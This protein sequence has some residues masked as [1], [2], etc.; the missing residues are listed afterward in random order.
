MFWKK[1]N[2]LPF[3]ILFLTALIVRLGAAVYWEQRIVHNKD[4]NPGA[5]SPFYFGDSDTYWQLGKAIAEGE[6]Y[7]YGSNYIHR[8]PGYPVLLAPLFLIGELSLPARILAARIE[9]IIFGVLTVFAVVLLAQQLFNNR[10][11][12][13][14]AGFFAALDPLQIIMSVMILSEAPFCFFM[15]LQLLFF[16]KGFETIEKK[17]STAGLWF[18]ILSGLMY[19]AAV[20]CRPSWLYFVPF[21]VLLGIIFCPYSFKRIIFSGAVITAVLVLCL[22]PWWYRNYQVSGHFVSTTLQTGPAF[23]DGLSPTATGKSE[24]TFVAVFQE[25]FFREEFKEP[26]AYAPVSPAALEYKLNQKMKEAAINWA[27]KHPD[28]ALELAIRKFFRLWNFFPN[29]ESFSSITM[30]IAVFCSFS[31]VFL[32]GLCGVIGSFRRSV[33]VMILWY[34]AVYITLLHMIFVSSIRYRCP[35]MLG[36]AILAAWCV[37]GLLQARCKSSRKAL[38]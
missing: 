14:L 9:N 17:K 35:A 11:I 32:L 8:M 21:A 1:N 31:P 20:Y 29:E 18:F 24:M 27:K 34:P 16:V 23:Y 4:F 2:Y 26:G 37:V 10:S 12:S 33:D 36:L 38:Q 19:A 6:P 30:K 7:K 15:M 25:E 13:L 3:I 22:L 5:S 28:K